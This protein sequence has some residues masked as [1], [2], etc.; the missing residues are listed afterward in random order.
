V[1][2]GICT[3]RNLAS[4]AA[5]FSVGAGCEVQLG[6]LV[7]ATDFDGM[8]GAAEAM[9]MTA[10]VARTMGDFVIAERYSAR[11]VPGR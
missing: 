4:C 11:R 1:E 5:R 7:G 9:E 8:C 3:G 2:N 10:T 6:G